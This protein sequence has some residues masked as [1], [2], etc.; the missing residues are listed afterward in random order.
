MKESDFSDFRNKS[1]LKNDPVDISDFTV[2]T[3][4]SPEERKDEFT[5]FTGNPNR[6]K[7]GNITVNCAY[8]GAEKARTLEG[9]LGEVV[10]R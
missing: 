9:V 10:G 8:S 1:D 4:L 3:A 7:V 5:K 6:V 2:D